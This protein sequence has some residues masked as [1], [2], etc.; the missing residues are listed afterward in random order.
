MIARNSPSKVTALPLPCLS[1]GVCPLCV[2]GR[3][4]EAQRAPGAPGAARP[5][6][7][8]GA[9]QGEAELCPGWG[10]ARR[11]RNKA[12]GGDF[13]IFYFIIPP[14]LPVCFIFFSSRKPTRRYFS[15]ARC[16]FHPATAAWFCQAPFLLRSSFKGK[17]KE[18]ERN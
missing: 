9:G 8:R 18:R 13:I 15:K 11:S 2:C 17:K 5:R 7:P 3:G 12:E 1:V 14:P 10:G 16:I 4:D 6:E